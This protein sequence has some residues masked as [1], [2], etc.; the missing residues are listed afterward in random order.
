MVGPARLCA[1]VWKGGAPFRGG[2]TTRSDGAERRRLASAGR[3]LL[4]R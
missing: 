1:H 3:P 4:S 2:Q